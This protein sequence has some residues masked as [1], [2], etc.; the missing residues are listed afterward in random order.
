MIVHVQM[1]AAILTSSPKVQILAALSRECNL[2][3]YF[4]LSPFSFPPSLPPLP[5]S[6]P[7]L[8]PASLPHIPVT[9]YQEKLQCQEPYW[10][11]RM[12]SAPPL[13]SSS[14]GCGP[15]QSYPLGS[16][17]TLSG[18]RSSEGGRRCSNSTK[19]FERVFYSN[20]NQCNYTTKRENSNLYTK[21]YD[22]TTHAR[23]ACVQGVTHEQHMN[24]HQDD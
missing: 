22:V 14:W 20:M 5:F 9:S 3:V 16:V 4:H 18:A 7:P 24:K 19:Y 17:G 12:Q 23:Q 8:L 15:T 11:D 1:I 6:P 10:R 2:Q 13:Q 21:R